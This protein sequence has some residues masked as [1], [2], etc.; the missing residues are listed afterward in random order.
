MGLRDDRFSS[1]R[2][3]RME[4]SVKYKSAASG[5]TPTKA[6]SRQ[7][8]RTV[9]KA[10]D[11]L[12]LLNDR[13]EWLG[14][15][16]VARLLKLNSA[17]AHNLLRTLKAY[18]LVDQNPDTKK[19]QLG[20]GLVLLAGTKLGQLDLVTA[21]TPFMKNAMEMTGETITL[22]VLYDQELLY[23]A[24]IEGS[25]PVRVASRIGGSA[26]LHCSANGKALMAYCSEQELDA[27]LAKPLTKYNEKTVIS[28]KLLREDLRQ[29]RS[30]GYAVDFG[31]Y[32]AEVNGVAAPIRDQSGNVIA[33]MGI[34][35]PANRLPQKR[36]KQ[37]AGIAVEVTNKISGSLGWNAATRPY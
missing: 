23:L 18:G 15:R 36:I 32:I 1:A 2:A 9:V 4:T 7:P 33:S 34:I 13:Q 21:A 3:Q 35:A 31:A 11:V 29:V 30:R 28:P 16:E 6:S 12:R 27:I 19:Y 25:R 24:K 37:V 20:L 22:S 26:P 10:L 8:L 14:V 17:T 5:A